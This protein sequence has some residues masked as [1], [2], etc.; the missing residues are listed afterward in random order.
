MALINA[1][2]HFPELTIASK[3]CLVLP[4]TARV[5]TAVLWL[6]A[7]WG[8]SCDSWLR[9]TDIEHL[10]QTYGFAAVLVEGQHS[11]YVDMT[12]GPNWQTY[13][14]QTL[15]AYLEDQFGL[16]REAKRQ[17]WFAFGMGGFVA[18]RQ[19]MAG[20]CAAA[21]IARWDAELFTRHLTK[22]EELAWMESCYGRSFDK[23]EANPFAQSERAAMAAD[24]LLMNTPDEPT[25]LGMKR[26]YEHMSR[27]GRLAVWHDGL[28]GNAYSLRQ[29]F[30]NFF[31]KWAFA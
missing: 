9:G 18:F 13:V 29:E 1:H 27:V 4:D 3:F 28:A 31:V 23:E 15:P 14:T 25:Y 11:N 22:P 20:R 21:G 17:F 19:A 30:L 7:D 26:L 5:H 2:V 24:V 10:A 8:E 6:P 12:H 16:S